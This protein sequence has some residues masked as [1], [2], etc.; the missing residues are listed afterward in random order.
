[1]SIPVNCGECDYTGV[2]WKEEQNE[3]MGESL[4]VPTHTPANLPRPHVLEEEE[5]MLRCLGLFHC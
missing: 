3:E 5:L 4:R 2:E 1:M